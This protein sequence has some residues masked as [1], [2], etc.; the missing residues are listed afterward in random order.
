VL[1][2]S[3]LSKFSC[4]SFFCHDTYFYV[5]PL[6]NAVFG[7]KVFGLGF[8]TAMA[9]IFG[10]GN[11]SSSRIPGESGTGSP[12]PNSPIPDSPIPDSP[13]PGS[14]V[15]FYNQLLGFSL[16]DRHTKRR[17]ADELQVHVNAFPSRM[18]RHKYTV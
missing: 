8:I 3:R 18:R 16:D 7:F 5:Q 11:I 2:L 9:F 15:H 10:T 12:I 4:I 14:P 17:E 13:I 1:F 6:Y